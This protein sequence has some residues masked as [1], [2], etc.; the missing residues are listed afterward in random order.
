MGIKDVFFPIKQSFE[1]LEHENELET[2]LQNWNC[3][4]RYLI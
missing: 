3:M 1:A 4:V 2:L